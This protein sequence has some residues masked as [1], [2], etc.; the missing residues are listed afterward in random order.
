M[1][2]RD[3]FIAALELEEPDQVPFA[4]LISG[5]YIPLASGVKQTEFIYSDNLFRASC[6]LKAY[7][8]FDTDWIYVLPG[9]SRAEIER[10]RISWSEGKARV[11]DLKEGT[12]T[13]LPEDEYPYKAGAGMTEYRY[14][15]DPDLSRCI[16]DLEQGGSL[17]WTA[18]AP[19]EGRREYPE[20]IVKAVGG[21]KYTALL[22]S[23]PAY[24]AYEL[25]GER[26]FLSFYRDPE[27]LRKT[28]GLIK[29]DLDKFIDHFWDI[30]VDAFIMAEGMASSDCISPRSYRDFI[31]PLDKQLAEHVHRKGLDALLWFYGGVMDRLDALIEVG[32]D[33]LWVEESARGYENDLASIKASLDGRLCLM[34]NIDGR[35]LLYGPREVADEVKRC[36]EGAAAGGGYVLATGR[37]LSEDIP[38]S[39][40]TE[41]ARQTRKQGAYPRNAHEHSR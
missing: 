30:D 11:H 39:N 40:V 5:Q 18:Q 2:G 10:Y 12:I 17:G 25:L 20:A 29:A 1:N 36:V 8:R 7:Q 41:L 35:R 22:F 28:L 31:L 9:R 23:C 34:G 26:Y 3:R 37:P 16:R 4:P 27:G 15:D 33:C 38:L 13:L 32:A 24:R 19:D 21:R 6:A 14:R